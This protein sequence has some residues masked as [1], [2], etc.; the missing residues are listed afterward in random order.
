MLRLDGRVSAAAVSP[1]QN[2]FAAAKGQCKSET[3]PF[4]FYSRSERK[5]RNGL[6]SG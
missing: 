3:A 4:F 6:C 5:E 2:G 1:K